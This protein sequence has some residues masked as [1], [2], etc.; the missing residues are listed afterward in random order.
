MKKAILLA[1][2][3]LLVQECSVVAANTEGGATPYGVT[4]AAI[5]PAW[6]IVREASGQWEIVGEA[7]FSNTG[8]ETLVIEAI[9]LKVF[10]TNGD[11]LVDQ[12][13]GSDKFK[14]L[15][16]I[17]V[18]SPNGTYTELS[19][20]TRKLAPT[21]LGFCRVA[22]LAGK[23]SLPAAARVTVSFTNGKSETAAAA[24]TPRQSP[25]ES[26]LLVRRARRLDDVRTAQLLFGREYPANRI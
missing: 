14:D 26:L 1:L 17:A 22:A 19:A 2:V 8:T 11:L 15:I 5:R 12:S 23:V 3:F 21:D 16:M 25:D 13:Y 6:P 24:A 9:N 20:S 10:N 18:Q 4:L 7:F